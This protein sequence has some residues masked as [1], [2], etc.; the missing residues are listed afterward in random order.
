MGLHGRG[1]ILE[2]VFTGLQAFAAG[3]GTVLAMVLLMLDAFVVAKLAYLYTFL[4]D[5][6][7]MGRITGHQPR[8]QRT[9]ISAIPV[10]LNTFNHHLHIFFLKT[11]R[12]T[13]LTCGNTFDQYMFQ[14]ICSFGFLSFWIYV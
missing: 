2:P 3:L 13:G 11:K 5:V 8:C 7:G 12:G 1:R 9:H 4:Q 10:D 14:V 6:A